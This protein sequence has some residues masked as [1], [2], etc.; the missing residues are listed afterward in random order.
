MLSDGDSLEINR[1]LGEAGWIGMSWPEALGGR[2][3]SRLDA[4]L[5]EEVL[6]YHWLP[7]SSYLLSYK[8][9][10]AAI[11][12]FA[13]ALAPELLPGITR[14]ELVFCQGFSEPGAGS[15]L[16][17]LTTRAELRGR[18]VGRVGTQAVDLECAARRLDLPRGSHRFDAAEAQGDL[19][20]RVPDDDAGNRGANVRHPRGRGPVRGVSRPGRDPGAVSRRRAEP[21]LGRP[22][23]HARLRTGDGRE[24]RRLRL[25]GGCARRAAPRGRTPGRACRDRDRAASWSAECGTAALVPCGR[26]AGQGPAGERCLGDGEARR[27][28]SRPGGWQCGGRSARA[29][30]A[31]R[32]PSRTLRSRGV[33]PRCTAPRPARASPGARPTSSDSSSRGGG[34]ACDEPSPGSQG[35]RGRA[36]R[37]R[38]ACR[39]AAR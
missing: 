1:R 26:H 15:D 6:G 37:C 32:R 29:R 28:D 3:L 10:G 34:W 13:P 22:D 27:F 9:I 39:H 12:R 23:V 11:E 31:R 25:G 33:R 5:V 16:A 38:A 2:G 19:G 24:D 14:G 21:R 30:G 20:P 4:T 36:V 8:T 35:R 17:S 7:L 18:H